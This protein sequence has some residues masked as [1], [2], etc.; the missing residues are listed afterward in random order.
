M[1]ETD[2]EI[3]TLYKASDL[4]QVI[5]NFLFDIR[6][7]EKNLASIQPS[8][9]V[10]LMAA[11]TAANVI[12]CYERGQQHIIKEMQKGDNPDNGRPTNHP[13]KD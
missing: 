12:S 4:T 11:E 6:H 2:L 5:F 3:Q 8:V 7:K 9:T 1:D 13:T 10:L